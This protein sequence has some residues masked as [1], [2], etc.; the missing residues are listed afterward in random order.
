MKIL[1]VDDEKPARDRLKRLLGGLPPYQ[2]VAE[3]QNGQ[4]AL[5]QAEQHDPDIVLMDIR[6][7][8]M[9]GLEA[10]QHLARV[11]QPPAIIFTTAFSDHAL[12]AFESHAIDY[13][14]KPVKPERLEEALN[15]SQRLNRAQ[16]QDRLHDLDTDT[17]RQH[18][19]AR[20]RGNL[21]LIPLEDIFYFHAEQKYVTV[22]H[23]G[24]EVLIEEPLK[25]LEQEFNQHFHRIHRNALVR[26]DK[27]AGMKN[28]ADGHQ[29]VFNDIEDHLDVS[30][31]HL[32][33]VRNIL[34]SL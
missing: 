17:A 18:I 27:I 33:G 12:E 24:G 4:E 5:E 13:L 3:A 8:G 32:S 10:A 15:A 19:C 2:C 21:M 31:R 11:Q 20:V 30:R 22:R 14:L 1:I 16:M 6:M 28:K 34:K 7:P 9:D 26:I 25:S 29:L 23:A